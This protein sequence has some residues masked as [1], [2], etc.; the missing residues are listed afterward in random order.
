MIPDS[1]LERRTEEEER[2]RLA[3]IKAAL[4]PADLEQVNH[5]SGTSFFPLKNQLKVGLNL[6]ISLRLFN[7]PRL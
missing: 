5:S 4:S 6:S 1:D 3:G 7:Q 2:N